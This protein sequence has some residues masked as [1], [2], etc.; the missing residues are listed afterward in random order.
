M[1]GKKWI[2]AAAILAG[3]V[4]ILAPVAVRAVIQANEYKA[5]ARHSDSDFQRITDKKTI[6]LEVG[7]SANY[8]RLRVAMKIRH[9][10]MWFR[11]VDPTGNERLQGEVREGRGSFDTREVAATI[12][13][14]KLF[15]EREGASGDYEAHWRVR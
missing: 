7:S 11:L 4:A 2:V 9:G 3:N 1:N 12:G 13:V 5:D 8:A 10:R 6:D 15:I 14:W